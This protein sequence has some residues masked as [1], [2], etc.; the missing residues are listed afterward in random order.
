MVVSLLRMM[1]RE[2]FSGSP[3]YPALLTI[4]WLINRLGVHCL[5][6]MHFRGHGLTSCFL[7]QIF[8]IPTVVVSGE[9][10]QTQWCFK[11]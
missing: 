2:V 6:C 9:K 4:Q 3:C 1:I 8:S 5:A 11:Q 7:H 10:F